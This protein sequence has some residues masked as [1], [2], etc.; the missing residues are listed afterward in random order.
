MAEKARE[1]GERRRRHAVCGKE[2][3]ERERHVGQRVVEEHLHGVQQI[4][5]LHHVEDA[6][7]EAREAACADSVAIGDEEQR[8]HRAERHAAA[9]R[10]VVEAKLVQDDGHR[11]HEGDGHDHRRREP[12]APEVEVRENR[13]EHG[14]KRDEARRVLKNG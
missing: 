9:L 12:H 13:E 6:V 11:E 4:G 14:D 2:R 8:H 3:G 10:H 5:I 1:K 7:E